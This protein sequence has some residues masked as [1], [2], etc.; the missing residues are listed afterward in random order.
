MASGSIW[1]GIYGENYNIKDRHSKTGV[2]TTLVAALLAILLV[3]DPL[4]GLIISQILLSVQL[5]VTIFLQIYLTSSK[6]V[7]GV[8]ANKPFDRIRLWTVGI[9]VTALNIMLLYQLFF[10]GGFKW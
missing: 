6:K 3:G 8:H 2:V 4:K 10:S 5:P 1:A 7:M 9:A